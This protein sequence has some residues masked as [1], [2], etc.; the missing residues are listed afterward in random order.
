MSYFYLMFKNKKLK[1]AAGC[2]DIFSKM[3]S[4]LWWDILLLQEFNNI[5]L[6]L[7]Q[8]NNPLKCNKWDDNKAKCFNLS[9]YNMYMI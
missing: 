3:C 2:K 7:K 6:P 5:V 8:K 1:Q 9:S 4:K